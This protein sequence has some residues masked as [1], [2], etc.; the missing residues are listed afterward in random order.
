MTEKIRR[1]RKPLRILVRA[2]DSYGMPVDGISTLEILATSKRPQA[3]M[4]E[5]VKRQGDTS[6]AMLELSMASS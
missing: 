2:F 3:F 4:T 6:V 5:V 1:P